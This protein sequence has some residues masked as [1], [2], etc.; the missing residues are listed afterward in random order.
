MGSVILMA[1]AL[2]DL[3]DVDFKCPR[4]EKPHTEKD[5]YPKFEKS[6][7]GM[8]HMRCKGCKVWLGVSTDMK[9]DVVVWLKSEERK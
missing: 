5:W 8:I 1:G 6:K 4:C 9:G 2:I 3:C 7:H